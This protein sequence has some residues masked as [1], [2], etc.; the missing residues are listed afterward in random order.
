MVHFGGATFDYNFKTDTTDSNP[1]A[2]NVR[3][4]NSTQPSAT[5]MY[6]SQIDFAGSDIESFL[7]TIDSST[8]A[9]K[10]HVR[11]ADKDDAGDFVLFAISE[12]TDNGTWWTLDISNEASGGSAL[13]N[14]EDIIASF[15]VTGDQGAKGQ[16][17]ATGSQG[18]TRYNRYSRYNWNT[19]FNRYSRYT[20]NTR[21]N[22][23]TRYN[24]Y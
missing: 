4:N 10:G 16:K 7:E 1:G 8:S 5:E 23:N 11:L 15:V 14:N 24:R 20:R 9:V 21:Y 2:G 18:T 6:L 19:R 3:L 17:G 13:T 22:W 12:L